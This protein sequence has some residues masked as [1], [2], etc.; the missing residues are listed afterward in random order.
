LN[1]K[2]K[3]SPV[4]SPK[5]RKAAFLLSLLLHLILIMLYVF[6]SDKQADFALN[7]TPSITPQPQEK[8]LAFELVETPE[9][10]PEQLPSAQTDLASDQ[11]SKAEDMNNSAE[12]AEGLPFSDGISEAKNYPLEPTIPTPEQELAENSK[13]EN[14]DEQDTVETVNPDSDFLSELLQE[15]TAALKEELRSPESP[16]KNLDSSSS[17]MGGFS[18]N[19]YNWDFAPYLLSM[20]RRIRGNMSLPYAFSHL[21]AISGDILVHFTVLPSGIVSKLEILN[22]DAHYSLEQSSVNAI[23][24]SSAF[25]PLP[26]DFPEDRLEVTAKFS[27][28]ILKD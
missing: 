27:F 28:S 14:N 4:Y 22:S 18:F 26:T 7:S 15:K 21:G 8:R 2:R 19:T 11:S 25:Q 24:T 6:I 9:N 5:V 16:F 17:D 20:K 13:T 10:I 12:L 23:Q 3:N 1:L